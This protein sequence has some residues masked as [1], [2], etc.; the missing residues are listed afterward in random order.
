MIHKRLQKKCFEELFCKD[1]GG[2]IAFFSVMISAMRVNDGLLP[3][4]LHPI[5]RVSHSK[6][7]ALNPI[8]HSN[9]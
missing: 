7:S 1:L 8:P 6:F 3:G 4:K 5:L 9:A 2:G